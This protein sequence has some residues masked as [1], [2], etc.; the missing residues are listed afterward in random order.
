RSTGIYAVSGLLSSS[1]TLPAITNFAASN[2][3]S[4]SA[5]LAGQVTSTGDETPLVT[6]FCGT[7]NGGANAAAWSN[8]VSLNYQTSGFAQFIRGLPPGRPFFFPARAVNS[9]GTA[10]AS[11][12]LSF[13]PPV[14]SVASVTNLPA[15]NITPF[16]ASLNGQ[17]LSTGGDPPSITFYY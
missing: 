5:T 6:L 17:V 15:D 2:I 1:V 8:S 3:T 16:T 12:S 10:W 14:P 7:N 13:L 11:P 4:F 9:A